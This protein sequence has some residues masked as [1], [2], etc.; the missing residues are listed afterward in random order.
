MEKPP[1]EDARTETSPALSRILDL[2]PAAAVPPAEGDS[3]WVD[4]PG[5]T[6]NLHSLY[7]AP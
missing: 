1:A 7:G 3:T 2:V 5:W 4:T 6:I